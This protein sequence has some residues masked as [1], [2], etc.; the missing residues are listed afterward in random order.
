MTRYTF[1]LIKADN[2]HY[3]E[4]GHIV[5]ANTLLEAIEKF[6][7]INN[8]TAPAYLDLPAYEKYMEVHFRDQVGYVKY[9]I[10]W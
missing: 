2:P 8:L 7:R 4:K 3:T 10:A 1:T 6:E 9:M 5:F